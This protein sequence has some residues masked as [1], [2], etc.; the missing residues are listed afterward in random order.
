[1]LR[2]KP[3]QPSGTRGVPSAAL[4]SLITSPLQATVSW[5]SMTA[6][7][8]DPAL[9]PDDHRSKAPPR[10]W[11]RASKPLAIHP[12]RLSNPRLFR[13][14]ERELLELLVHALQLLLGG[15]LNGSCC[16][17]PSTDA[18]FSSTIHHGKLRPPWAHN[19][20]CC[21]DTENKPGQQL[22]QLV[23]RLFEPQPF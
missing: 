4:I 18:A 12:C 6:F 15:L 2:P 19:P 14:E 20:R 16:S 3:L 22:F 9:A 5:F 10:T 1:M 23:H 21:R 11:P 17:L 8:A 13:H 7:T